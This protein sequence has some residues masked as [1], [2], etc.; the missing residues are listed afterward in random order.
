MV[1]R[2]SLGKLRTCPGA[3]G[4]G[5]RLLGFV[6][7]EDPVRAAELAGARH[8]CVVVDLPGRAPQRVVGDGR[9]KRAPL[10]AG[11]LDQGPHGARHPARHAFEIGPG[12]E[13]GTG[14]A[15]LSLLLAP[16]RG[17]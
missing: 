14:R 7:I 8:R 13:S 9:S 17:K 11:G 4:H 10:D 12:A 16:R 3:F 15:C 5:R 6:P 2:P 1:D